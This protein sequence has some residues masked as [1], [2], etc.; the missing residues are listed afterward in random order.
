MVQEHLILGVDEQDLQIERRRWLAENPRVE[1]VAT[2]VRREPPSL[3]TRI[4]GNRVPRLSMLVRYHAA[5][6]P[7]AP[8]SVSSS[9]SGNDSSEGNSNQRAV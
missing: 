5:M 8:I 3:L 1:V 2:V 9:T 6:H 4:G 7:E